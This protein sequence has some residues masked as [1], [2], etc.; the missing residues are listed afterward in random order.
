MRETSKPKPTSVPNTQ[1]H[2]RMRVLCLPDEVDAMLDHFALQY[3]SRS[4]ACEAAIRR[5]FEVYGEK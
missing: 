1:R 4:Q 5:M 2:R 3:G